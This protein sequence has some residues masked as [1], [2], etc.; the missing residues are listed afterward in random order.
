MPLTKWQIRLA[1]SPFRATGDQLQKLMEVLSDP[2]EWAIFGEDR[3]RIVFNIQ[4]AAVTLRMPRYIPFENAIQNLK[5]NEV[6]IRPGTKVF[7]PG[8]EGFPEKF[9]IED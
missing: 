5:A 8:P 9:P 4:K 2:N 1:F 7:K 3:F 6:L